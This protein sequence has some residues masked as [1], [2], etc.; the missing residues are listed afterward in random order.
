M[1]DY[2]VELLHKKDY[3]T[4]EWSGGLTTE[5]SIAPE[6]SVYADRDFMWRLSSATVELEEERFYEPA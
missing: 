4:T 5:L 2:H 1:A 3:K 6:G